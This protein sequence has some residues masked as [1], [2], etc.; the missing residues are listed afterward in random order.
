MDSDSACLRLVSLVWQSGSVTECWE[1]VMDPDMKGKDGPK[2][3]GKD[4]GSDPKTK[5]EHKKGP[6]KM[7]KDY[8]D[9]KKKPNTTTAAAKTTTK[10]ANEKKNK[11]LKKPSSQQNKRA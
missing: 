1:R 6:L 8:N 3:N 7:H 11:V 4:K 9:R 5:T 10:K 2:D